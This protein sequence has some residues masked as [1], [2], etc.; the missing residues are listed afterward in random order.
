MG[1]KKYVPHRANAKILLREYKENTL[2]L[3]RD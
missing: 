1:I 2:V 3:G